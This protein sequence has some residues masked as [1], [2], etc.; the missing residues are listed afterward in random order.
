MKNKIITFALTFSVA[1]SV[2][3][4][5]KKDAQDNSSDT[6]IL[7]SDTN[8]TPVMLSLKND[9]YTELEHKNIFLIEAEKCEAQK[10]S[11]TEGTLA[12][13][14]CIGNKII[15]EIHPADGGNTSVLELFDPESNTCKTIGEITLSA[16]YGAYSCVSG[17]RYFSMIT[18]EET[19]GKLYGKVS[20]YDSETDKLTST[21]PYE[22]YNIVQYITPYNDEDL[23]FMYYEAATQD[24]VIMRLNLSTNETTEIFRESN[25][26][27][28]QNSPVALTAD[29]D[30]IILVLQYIRD[31]VYHTQ[32]EWISPE[33]ELLR[34]EE[35]DFYSFFD[36]ADYP[37]TDFE[38]CGDHYYLKANVEE[39]EQYFI[40]KRDGDSFRVV[41]PAIC[42][43]NSLAGSSFSNEENLLFYQNENIIGHILSA[44]LKSGSLTTYEISPE[45]L[46]ENEV[47]TVK[48]CSDNDLMIFYDG[49]SG[50][51]ECRVVPDYRSIETKPFNSGIYMTEEQQFEQFIENCDPTPE[52]IEE[53]K[54]TM[55]EHKDTL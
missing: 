13:V 52:E 44:D 32:F 16:E 36:T 42:K 46:M 2:L 22:I 4:S 29:E 12:S 55:E 14:N 51:P 37:I 10:C 21:E 19:D 17:S 40:F 7:H 53:M 5:C 25:T 18:A 27:E 30:S 50:Y 6:R 31:G 49:S 8:S 20:V 23:L 1:L 39:Q 24:R 33:G 3:C 28:D 54:K 35:P 9:T 41:L 26:N 38:I 15:S 43:L 47:K 11:N 48:R 34:T 45:F